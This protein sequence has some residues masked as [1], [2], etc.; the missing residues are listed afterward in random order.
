MILDP[1]LREQIEGALND[2]RPAASIENRGLPP[3]AYVC[4]GTK[5]GLYLDPVFS[6]KV[7]Q[8]HEAKRVSKTH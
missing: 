2:A 7:A 5:Y 4:F 6:N 8:N 1:F 3:I